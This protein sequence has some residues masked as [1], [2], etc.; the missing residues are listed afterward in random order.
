MYYC[1][2]V[3]WMLQYLRRL[4][5]VLDN[6]CYDTR[7]LFISGFVITF[8]AISAVLD[9]SG[10]FRL[11]SAVLN[12]LTNDPDTSKTVLRMLLDVVTGTQTALG[13]PPITAVLLCSA[14]VSFGGLSV[15][16]QI[17][18]CLSR[19]KL[20][21]FEVFFFRLLHSVLTAIATYIIISIFD[22]TVTTSYVFGT[23]PQQTQ[24][25]AISTVLF[26]ICCAF[27]VVTVD[28]NISLLLQ[29]RK[30]Q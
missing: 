14:G 11:L 30:R 25:G 15:L 3:V 8:S 2:L 29:R 23:N 10:A 5:I 26:L 17:T 22:T 7:L 9:A 27:F 24:T 13:C 28:K 16:S 6:I 1:I 12:P 21:F 18:F 20:N 19:H 4:G